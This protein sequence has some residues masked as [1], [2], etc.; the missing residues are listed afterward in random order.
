MT[1]T[2]KSIDQIDVKDKRIF[3]RVD[4]NVPIENGVISN[5]KRIDST[6][7][8]IQHL[9]KEGC[10][11]IVI[12]SHLGRPDGTI[13]PELTL[14]PI[15][16]ILEKLISRPVTFLPSCVGDETRNACQSPPVGSVFLL[17]NVRF[18]AE[19]E[20]FKIENGVKIKSS[21]EEIENFRKELTQ[22]ADIYVNDAF[23][24]VHRAHST[25]TGINLSPRVS[26]FLVKKE[27]DYFKKAFDK[28]DRPYLAILGGAK[29]S[30][31]ISIIKTFLTKVDVML[32]CGGMSYTFMNALNGM[33]IGKSIFDEKSVEFCR[34]VVKEAESLGVKMVFAV[35]FVICDKFDKDANV[36]C[37][38]VQEGID[39][40]WEG[41]DCGFKS[42]DLFE[43]NYFRGEN[44]NVEWSSWRF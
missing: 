32:I 28:I 1:F 21:K 25:M 30:D 26:G 14:R 3:L 4:Y 11:S 24:T 8:T 23:G 38:S 35:D 7:P 20:G 27:L 18:H 17:E 37:V 31:K 19:E 33:K 16:P 42:R 43:K 12:V 2:K 6:I 34:N 36:K 44:D 13:K 29:V 41:V 39:D 9:L 10:R 15:I 22:L 40:G 5:T